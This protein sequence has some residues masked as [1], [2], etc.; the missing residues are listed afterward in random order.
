MYIYE[1]G[2]SVIGICDFQWR[3]EDGFWKGKGYFG[4]PTPK[5]TFYVRS[6][7]GLA[8]FY[9]KFIQ[10][11]N[12]IC[13]PLT[14]C[15]KNGISMW[16]VVAMN[17]FEDLNKNLIEQAILV[18]PYFNKVFQVDCYAIGAILSQEESLIEWFNEKLNDD[19]KKNYIYC[20]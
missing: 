8:I 15:M 6:F 14:E 5:C 20:Q 12:E 2:I 4:M 18:L 13:A 11:F 19:K 10:N 16:T 9:R 1:G 7:C 3:I 17:Y